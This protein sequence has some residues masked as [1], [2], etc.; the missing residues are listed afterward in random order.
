MLPPQ[1]VASKSVSSRSGSEYALIFE[2]L[3]ELATLNVLS[4][5]SKESFR[6]SYPSFTGLCLNTIDE[7]SKAVIV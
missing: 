6:C 2:K 4:H 7:A 3:K 1:D 5:N